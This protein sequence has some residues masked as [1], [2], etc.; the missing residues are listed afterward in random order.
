MSPVYRS[1][2]ET[3]DQQIAALEA[4][5]SDPTM[6]AQDI[7]DTKEAIAIARS[8]REKYGKIIESEEKT[9]EGAYDIADRLADS[10]TRDINKAKSGLGKVGQLAVD[11]GVAGTQMGADAVLGLATGGSALFPMFM[12]SAGGSAQ[13][14]RRAGATHEQQVNYGLA[15]GALSVATEKIANVAAPFKKMFG[16]R[17]S[18]TMPL[19]AHLPE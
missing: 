11:V 3:L 15:S 12:R 7:A 19:T 16:G 8:E 18:S 13:E 5:L 4:T 2:A 17:A 6:T 14:A 10:G 1:Q 9:V